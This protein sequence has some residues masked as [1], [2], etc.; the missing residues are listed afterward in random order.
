MYTQN[1]TLVVK[2]KISVGEM[3]V[4]KINIIEDIYINSVS[5]TP[6]G[7]VL[8]YA[9]SSA[10][11]GWLLCNGSE[12]S[13]TTYSK[14]F[15][16]IGTTYG[17]G[18]GTTTFNLP[19]LQDRI[20]V[21]KGTTN[22]T[23]GAA[24]GQDS[25]TLTTNELPTHSHTASSADAGSHNHTGSTSTNGSHTHSSNAVG[26][27]GQPGLYYYD[28]NGT[29]GSIDSSFNGEIN[30]YVSAALTINSAGDHSHTLTTNSA[31]THSHTITVDNTGSG[32]S[33]S[34]RNKYIVMNYIIRC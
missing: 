6:V 4:N 2:D 13:R 30:N 14:L 19:N 23:I 15:N 3:S 34:I 24:G 20:P 32:Q 22:A 9:G 12:V 18:D 11:S 27:F 29:A 21:G 7:S 1:Q 25:V 17:G 33:F 28:G 26:G 5:Y 16:I 10:P 8:V 31:G